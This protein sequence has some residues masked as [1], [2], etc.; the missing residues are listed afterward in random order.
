MS[1][2][3]VMKRFCFEKVIRSWSGSACD[4]PFWAGLGP[5][6]KVNMALRRCELGE[7]SPAEL[8]VWYFSDIV[9]G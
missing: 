9:R 5:G 3:A 6:S 1:L 8:A 7:Q 2:S 4:G